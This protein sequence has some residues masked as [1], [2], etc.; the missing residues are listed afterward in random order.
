METSSIVLDQR[1]KRFDLNKCS[2]CQKSSSLESTENG[3]IRIIEV[4]KIR[5]NNVYGRLTS[6]SLDSEL[7]Y[8]DN[9]GHKKAL[10]RI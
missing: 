4:A 2:V 10:K 6:L 8:I 1:K 5:N 7:K 3:W 9:N